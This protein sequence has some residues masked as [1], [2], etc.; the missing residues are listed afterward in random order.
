MHPDQIR[1]GMWVRLEDVQ[2]Y[3]P[4]EPD[5][6]WPYGVQFSNAQWALSNFG[7]IPLQVVAYQFPFCMVNTGPRGLLM[8]DMRFNRL[9]KC[10]EKVVGIF[11]RMRSRAAMAELPAVIDS[12]AGSD[13]DENEKVR[14]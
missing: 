14:V 13:G 8:V 12:G 4:P 3:K 2:A 11:K 6:I 7:G 5:Q 1:V 9:G 10:D